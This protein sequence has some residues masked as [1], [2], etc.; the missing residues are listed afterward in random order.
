MMLPRGEPWTAAEDATLRDLWAFGATV[1][2]IALALPGRTFN[3]VTGRAMRLGLPRRPSP[4]PHVSLRDPRAEQRDAE[5]RRTIDAEVI[6][7]LR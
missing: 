6:S 7:E 3:A 4:L 2:A 1:R 5:Y